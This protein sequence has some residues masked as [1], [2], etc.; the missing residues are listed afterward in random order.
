MLVEQRGDDGVQSDRLALSRGT[1]HQQ[2]RHLRQVE[3]VVLVLDRA[4]DHHRK[5]GLRLL[6]PQRTHGR[7]H[8]HDLLVAVRHLDTDGPLA[9]DRSDDADTRAP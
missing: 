9:R 1:G 3:D 7:I 6:E 5:F 2:V 8:R 4:A